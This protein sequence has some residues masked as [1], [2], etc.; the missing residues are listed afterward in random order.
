M[1][2]LLVQLYNLLKISQQ[3]CKSYIYKTL[4]KNIFKIVILKSI[5]FYIN[6]FD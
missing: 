4:K 2:H 3:L 1:Y 6:F 5:P